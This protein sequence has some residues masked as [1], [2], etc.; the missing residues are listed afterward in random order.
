MQPMIGST[1]LTFPIQPTLSHQGTLIIAISNIKPRQTGTLATEQGKALHSF[2][3]DPE[4]KWRTSFFVP[5]CAVQYGHLAPGET[6]ALLPAMRQSIH[7]P[8]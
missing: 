6:P 5:D 7:L 8:E 3:T 2:S 4:F 1:P